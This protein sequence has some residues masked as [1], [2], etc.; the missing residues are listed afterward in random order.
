MGESVSAID[1]SGGISGGTLST[2]IEMLDKVP[3]EILQRGKRD[4]CNSPSTYSMVLR[5]CSLADI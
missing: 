4:Y 5:R 3:R 1:L 2:A